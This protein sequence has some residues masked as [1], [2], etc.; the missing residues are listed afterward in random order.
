[1]KIAFTTQGT[2]WDAPMDARFGRTHFFLVFD[3]E[4]EAIEIVDNTAVENEAHGAGPKTAQKLIET[5]ASVL[6][7]GNGPGGNAA[8]VLETTGITVHVG[9]G[10]M[11]VR[12]ALT[13]YR[14]GDLAEM[15]V[16]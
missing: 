11:T 10:D 4:T 5:G 6:I 16:A 1:M 7:T 3:E 13:A 12:E 8:S 2:D 14:Q 9:A 15:G